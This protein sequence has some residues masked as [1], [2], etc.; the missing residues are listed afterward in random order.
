MTLENGRGRGATP[1][2]SIW[3]PARTSKETGSGP[4]NRS[5]AAAIY[6]PRRRR[7]LTNCIIDVEMSSGAP[8]AFRQSPAGEVPARVT[9]VPIRLHWGRPQ[10]IC[11][12]PANFRERFSAAGSRYDAAP[13]PTE[14]RCEAIFAHF[15]W[16]EDWIEFLK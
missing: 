3:R 10:F 1:L 6:R 9:G 7:P 14:L 4:G 12:A 2:I 5:I 11:D 16:G 15:V 13:F 8:P